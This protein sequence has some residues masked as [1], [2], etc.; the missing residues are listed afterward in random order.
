MMHPRL[1][2]AACSALLGPKGGDLIDHDP[3]AA[4]DEPSK[5]YERLRRTK[6]V[7]KILF[8]REAPPEIWA[9]SSEPGEVLV[10]LKQMTGKTS[11]V[12]VDLIESVAHLKCR[13]QVIN[14]YIKYNRVLFA[15]EFLKKIRVAQRTQQAQNI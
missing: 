11:R 10:S 12:H 5:K 6:V 4:E 8:G 15:Y 9:W 2:R 13:V 7:Y 3:A 1:Y 14:L